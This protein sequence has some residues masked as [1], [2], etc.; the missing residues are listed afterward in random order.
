MILCNL[1]YSK[2]ILKG[3]EFF[4]F[5]TKND[6]VPFFRT[7]FGHYIF[8]IFF[9]PEN[10]F[11]LFHLSGNFSLWCYL[12][13]DLSQASDLNLLPGWYVCT[14]VR[15]NLCKLFSTFRTLQPLDTTINSQV[16]SYKPKTSRKWYLFLGGFI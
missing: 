16:Q 12:F 13:D 2:Q 8:L 1:Y 11:S 15:R 9:L 5:L 6:I 7:T 3:P 10:F 4:N 14:L